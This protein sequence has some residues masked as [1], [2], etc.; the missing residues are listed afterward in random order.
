MPAIMQWSNQQ[1]WYRSS[2]A[3]IDMKRPFQRMKSCDVFVGI[4]LARMATIAGV[5][6]SY[7]SQDSIADTNSVGAGHAR[8]HAM[9]QS[10]T[11]D[12]SSLACIDMKR[13]FQR[14]EVMRRACW[15]MFLGWPQS[16]AWP[17]PTGA[18]I[19]LLAWPGSYTPQQNRARVARLIAGINRHALAKAAQFYSR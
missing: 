14:M 16:P 19:R 15:H 6:G 5:A 3:C 10:T 12:R 7:R 17:A 13:P 1:H 2:L 18:K 9:A 11:L 8:A 4:C